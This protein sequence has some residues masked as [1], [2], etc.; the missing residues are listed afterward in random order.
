M[1]GY[2]EQERFLRTEDVDVNGEWRFSG[3]FSA[4]QEVA[5]AHCDG[6]GLGLRDLR[7]QN[8]AWV[9]TRARLR[10]ER[11]P[12]AGETVVV[13]TWPKPP[14]HAFFPRYYRFFVAGEPVGAASMLYAQLDLETRRMAKPWLNGNDELTCA[15]EPPLP[16]PGNLPAPDG[17]AESAARTARYSDVDVNGHVNN[18]RYLDWFCDCFPMEWHRERRLTDVLVHY[19]REVIPG[20]TVALSLNRE[21]AQ[22]VLRGTSEG[23]LC[24]AVSGEWEKRG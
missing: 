1:N 11:V 3:M 7:G 6:Y 20:E 18:A 19:D 8:L 12:A 16:L 9:V 2:F 10:L 17:P 13:R 5:A 4:M 22:S 15:L 21:D 24:F 23:T 14:R